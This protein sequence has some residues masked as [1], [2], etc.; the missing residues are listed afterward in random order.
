MPCASQGIIIFSR[1][2]FFWQ[3]EGD[4]GS[5]DVRRDYY[6]PGSRWPG[7]AL[8]FRELLLL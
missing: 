5:M 2:G 1:T 7:L 6:Y 8:P 3:V 4:L